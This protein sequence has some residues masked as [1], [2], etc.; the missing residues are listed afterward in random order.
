MRLGGM[1]GAGSIGGS[2]QII[3]QL[4]GHPVGVFYL[5]KSD[6]LVYDESKGG[7]VYKTLDIDGIDGISYE[8]GADRYIAGQA[9]PKTY[10]GANI[11]FRW[12]QFD[13]SVQM[14]GA[15]GQKI[16]N[17]TSLTYMNMEQYPTY[18][19]MEK[20]PSR[21]I[22]DQTVTDYW[23]E[24]GDYLHFDY[25][26]VGWNL[27]CSKLQYLKNLR[28]TFSVNNITTITC[29]SGFSQRINS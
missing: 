4:V 15:F 18:N 23:L 21:N 7:Y 28:V 16:Y 2:N 5:P 13:I 26:T 14:N 3:Y 20:A 10:L 17:G 11:N 29:I 6:G 27:D 12:K 24:K 19:V 8:D 22:M 1:N 25:V 9:M